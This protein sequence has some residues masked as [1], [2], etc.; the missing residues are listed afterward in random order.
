MAS[1]FPVSID[2]LNRQICGALQQI[3]HG[4][5]TPTDP[6]DPKLLTSSKKIEALVGPLL[7]GARQL[8]IN[9]ELQWTCLDRSASR[10]L[11]EREMKQI[12]E[13]ADSVATGKE[14]SIVSSILISTKLNEEEI[15]ALRQAI[16][17]VQKIYGLEDVPYRVRAPYPITPT[18]EPSQTAPAL[19]SL[20]FK[21]H[22]LR[23]MKLAFA[24]DLNNYQKVTAVMR[25]ALLALNTKN[26][27]NED[28][29]AA[30][31]SFEEAL[32][33]CYATAPSNIC[34]LEQAPYVTAHNAVMDMKETFNIG[35]VRRW[36]DSRDIE[37]IPKIDEP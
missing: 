35:P 21:N 34:H 33:F 36:A 32:A 28:I 2:I 15:K 17:N 25:P 20:E 6:I 7:D 37:I 10:V 1:P 14:A 8:I 3:C 18:A 12:L 4:Q 19:T 22:C 30:L 16:L 29:R 27:T 23:K 13:S 5:N 24:Q 31:G 11:N 26:L 9:R